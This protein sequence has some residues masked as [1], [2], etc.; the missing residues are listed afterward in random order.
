MLGSGEKAGEFYRMI[1]PIEHARSKEAANK[2]KVE[3]YVVAADIYGASNLAGR[4]G[5]TWYTG[6][7]SW[8][9]Q[10][11]IEYILGFQIE[12]N[13][14]RINPCI[15]KDWKEFSMRYKF[16]RSIYHIKVHNLNGKNTGVTKV[17]LNGEVIENKEI[18]LVDD[19][20]VNEIVIEM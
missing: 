19:G 10:A 12:N 8:F 4:G 14:L 20:K 7:S 18:R 16:G 11:G 9:Y 17:I 3:P 5:W 13:V 1:T 6:S 15:P 2:Y